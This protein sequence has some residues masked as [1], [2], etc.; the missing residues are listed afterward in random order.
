MLKKQQQHLLPI[1]LNFEI[2]KMLAK[3]YPQWFFLL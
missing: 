3:I 2:L 1:I